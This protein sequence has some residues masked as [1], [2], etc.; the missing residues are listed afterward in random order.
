MARQLDRA[1]R[2]PASCVTGQPWMV[3]GRQGSP[4]AATD[5][6]V[7]RIPTERRGRLKAQGLPRRKGAE[8][9]LTPTAD[10]GTR[11]RLQASTP[12]T[13]LSV[14]DRGS[15]SG[16]LLPARPGPQPSGGAD[17]EAH[18]N[19]GGETSQLV[20]I[21]RKELTAE[22]PRHR[23]T[24]RDG[25]PAP[26]QL[27]QDQPWISG[28]GPDHQRGPGLDH[29]LPAHKPEGQALSKISRAK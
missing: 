7:L 24:R 18:E 17:P 5:E 29:S 16:N 15:R 14:S 26:E 10:P 3:S 12:M 23:R 13:G 9:S 19:K 4:Q 8:L 1:A 11:R 22:N 28:I 6:S 27:T 25:P 20:P 2:L 21:R